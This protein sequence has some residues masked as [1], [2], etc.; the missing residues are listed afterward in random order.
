MHSVLENKVAVITGG[1]R[2][3]GF[4]I[5]EKLLQNGASVVL[6][7]RQESGVRQAAESLQ[8]I[9]SSRTEGIVADVRIYSQVE[10]LMAL[11]EEKFGGIDILVNNAGIGVFGPVDKI[12]PEEWD[13]VI[14]TN[15]TGC[16]YCVHAAV[17]CMKRR[18]G[19]YILNISSLAGKNAFAGGSAYNASKFGLNGL[20]EAAMLD[21]RYE[22][23]R[24]S[25]IMPGSV[26]T[27]FGR[28]GREGG[29]G[30]PTNWKIDAQDVAQTAL[31]L[32]R[33]DPRTM[34]SRVE[35]RPS[36]PPRK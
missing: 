14:G 19:G 25:Y 6:C 9:A 35:M 28:S 5:A 23:I 34:I 3:I 12:P 30:Q 33:T 21:L 13:A 20:S 24:V 11:T 27:D 15:L 29:S 16:F 8:Q 4:R 22:N 1:S 17:P 31:D 32:L 36:K 10:R 18:G 2:G 7:G 26:E